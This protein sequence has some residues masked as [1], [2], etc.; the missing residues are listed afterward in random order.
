[1]WLFLCFFFFVVFFVCFFFY[2]Y[3]FIFVL[4]WFLYFL[5]NRCFLSRNDHWHCFFF[6]FFFCFFL[7]HHS[8]MHSIVSQPN[9]SNRLQLIPQLANRLKVGIYILWHNYCCVVVLFLCFS[10]FF[11][12]S[13]FRIWALFFLVFFFVIW[14]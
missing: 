8:L 4:L 1:M 5:T 6:F 3:L 7:Q 13:V 12:H 11:W 2:I 9:R 14:N 10:L